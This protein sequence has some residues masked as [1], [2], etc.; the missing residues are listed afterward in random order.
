MGAAAPLP[1]SRR[2]TK[3]LERSLESRMVGADCPLQANSN[4]QEQSAYARA[5]G[6]NNYEEKPY[7]VDVGYRLL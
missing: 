7:G 2:R 3:Q 5:H 6:S 1:V 4:K